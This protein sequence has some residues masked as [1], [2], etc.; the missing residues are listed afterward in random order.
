M[1]DGPGHLPAQ[2]AAALE[3]LDDLVR[4]FE[5]HPDDAVQ[6]GLIGVLRAV[7]VIHRG[8]LDRLVALL[9]ARGLRQEALTDPHVALLFGLYEAQDDDADDPRAR[10]EAA[11]AELRPH[12]ASHGGQLEVVAAE[13]G[14]VNIRLLGACT[15]C[16]GSPA[17]LG[18]LVEQALRDNL[19][20]FVRM[21]VSP[22]A[23]A[24]AAAAQRRAPVLIPLSA[25]SRGGP[26]GGC[27]SGGGCGSQA[28]GAAP[29]GDA[30]ARAR[31]LRR[32]HAAWRRRVRRG[33]R[34][35]AGRLAA[36]GSRASRDR[37]RGI[38]IVHSLMDGYDAL[39]I[40]DA[41]ERGAQP[42]TVFVLVPQVPDVATPTFDEW[43][44]QLSD[45]HLAEPSRILR[46][47]RAAGVLPGHVGCQ[48][49]TCED[50]AEALSAPVAASVPVAADRVRELVGEV[51]TTCSS[52]GAAALHGPPPGGR[53]G[54]HG[55]E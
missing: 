50:F 40:V 37:H 39:V 41:V 32:Q 12:V 8:A 31:R 3:R 52:A 47:A 55:R 34:R 7:D 5:Q 49:E 42:G 51:L 48:P 43:L 27:G 54:R 30:A 11:V 46:I 26:A 23:P 19:P 21:E 15:A 14:V 6:D 38:G 16:S 53:D 13:D 1:T 44:A 4:A 25:L 36:R 24:H 22:T 35:G 10:A 45:M 20:E 2:V 9:D 29:A 28:G 18:D 17:A 33:G